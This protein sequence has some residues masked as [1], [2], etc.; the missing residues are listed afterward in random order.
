MKN[1]CEP[2]RDDYP[3]SENEKIAARQIHWLKNLSEKCRHLNLCKWGRPKEYKN[4]CGQNKTLKWTTTC[5]NGQVENGTAIK[6]MNLL[7]DTT[8]T[9]G[10][11]PT[12]P[13]NCKS[14]P[15]YVNKFTNEVLR[16]PKGL[17]CVGPLVGDNFV[18]FIPGGA[19]AVTNAITAAKYQ[20]ND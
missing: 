2:I 20:E 11:D 8:V 10:E 3:L 5:K 15:I 1:C 19:L 18:R 9:L 13:V 4:I 6:Q 17:Y 16:A 12:K 7:N 14:N